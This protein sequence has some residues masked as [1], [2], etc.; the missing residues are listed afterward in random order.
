MRAD[1]EDV[2]GVQETMKGTDAHEAGA[3][4]G[5]SHRERAK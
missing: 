5:K 3:P 2:H 1:E 4:E